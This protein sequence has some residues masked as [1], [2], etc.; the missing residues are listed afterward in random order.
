M[1]EKNENELVFTS[2]AEKQGN[3]TSIKRAA[4]KKK[5]K[6][7]LSIRYVTEVSAN[8]AT[9]GGGGEGCGG[10]HEGPMKT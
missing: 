3:G 6:P 9:R 5:K 7:A 4:M 8:T 1:N 10:A 2:S